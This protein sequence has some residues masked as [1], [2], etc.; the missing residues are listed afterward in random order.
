DD[1]LEVAAADPTTR[2]GGVQAHCGAD[3][4]RI[5]A[6]D[7]ARELAAGGIGENDRLAAAEVANYRQHA[8]RQQALL[9]LDKRGLGERMDRER[10]LGRG[11][12]SDPVLP[13]GQAARRGLE[14]RAERL[15][16]GD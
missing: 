13:A 2:F 1:F 14:V 11:A 15:A 4:L 6:D 12:I 16:S 10:A 5:A 7:A 9:A 3:L 8:G